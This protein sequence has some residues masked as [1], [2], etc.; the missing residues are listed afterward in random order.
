MRRA[1]RDTECRQRTP[2][3]DGSPSPG[4]QGEPS[5]ISPLG[6]EHN[7]TGSGIQDQMQNANLDAILRGIKAR[8]KAAKRDSNLP[9][10]RA[11]CARFVALDILTTVCA[12]SE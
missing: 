1:G 12:I 11:A 8:T 9:R 6:Y 3:R 5:V 7:R 2:G 10:R 4:L